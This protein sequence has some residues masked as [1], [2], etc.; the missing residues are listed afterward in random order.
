MPSQSR[1]LRVLY[2]IDH[3]GI[4]G[5]AERFMTGLATH[6]PADRVEVWVCST[7]LGYPAAIDYITAAGVRH[8]SLG[9]RRKWD[10]YRFG[11]LVSLLRRERFDVLHSH[12]F[13]SNTWAAT[14]GPMCGVPVTIAHEHNWS[15]S[16]NDLRIWLDG[17]WIGRRVTRFIA[18]SEANRQRMIELEGVP[19]EK[20][21]VVHTAYIPSPE[22]TGDI[23]AELGVGPETPVIGTAACLRPEKALDVLLEAHALVRERIPGAELVIAGAGPC[24]D[25]LQAQAAALGTAET[26]HFLGERFDVDSVLRGFDVGVMS[27]EWEGMPLFVFECMAADTPLVATSVGGLPEVVSDRQTGMLV[28]PGDPGALAGALTEVLGD[29]SL[30]RRL[31]AAA[32][33]RLPEHSIEAVAGRFADLYARLRAEAVRR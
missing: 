23:R 1:R 27:S 2:L 12:M 5:G 8:V 6:L 14:L 21:E 18:V 7:R 10:A 26:V 33:L 11:Q 29:R 32:A 20:I 28:P 4:T 24:L 25:A 9:R 13:G 15:Y 17:H 22:T 16:G 30:A 3:V 19:P 31:A